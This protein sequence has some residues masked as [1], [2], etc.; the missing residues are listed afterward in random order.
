MRQQEQ[1]HLNDYVKRFKQSCDVLKSHMGS[2][3]LDG[4]VEH[5]EEHQSETEVKEQSKLMEQGLERFMVFVLLG[6]S[7]QAKY[8][9]LM[10]R[11]IPNIQWK[12]I[13]IQKQL[14]QQQISWQIIDMTIQ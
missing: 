12:M 2:K 9:S 14:Q 7:D 10:N 3:W 11:L 8:H 4:F 6:N 1:E 5:T 13:N